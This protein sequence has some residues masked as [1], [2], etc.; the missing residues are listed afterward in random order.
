MTDTFQGILP[1]DFRPVR[2]LIRRRLI[3]RAAEKSGKP[4]QVVEQCVD[5]VLAEM[6]GEAK[7]SNRP[8]I[9][10]LLNGGF[11]KILELVLKLLPLFL[12]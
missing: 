9:D 12:A 6:E 7:A 3:D 11:E 8:F 10:W 4:R 1:A 2:N 5:M